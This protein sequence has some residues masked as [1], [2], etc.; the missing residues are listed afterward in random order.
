MDLGTAM[1]HLGGIATTT[2]LRALVTWRV[3]HEGL[4]SGEIIRRGRG[5]YALPGTERDV[6]VAHQF[7]ATLAV[8]SAA[9]VHGWK[10]LEP[11]VRPWLSIPRGTAV[12]PVLRR[13]AFVVRS[14]TSGVTDAMTTALD[15]LRHLP[16]REAACVV[17]SALR[18]GAVA[19]DHLER[20]A[21]KARGPGSARMRST[22]PLLSPLSANPFETCLGIIAGPDFQRQVPI[23]LPGFTVHPDLVDPVNR[24]VLEADSWEFHASTPELFGRDCE[25]YNLLTVAGWIV[26]RFTWK[27]VMHDPQGVRRIIDQA[28]ACRNNDK[29]KPQDRLEVPSQAA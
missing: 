17:D 7:R 6:L 4:A 8:L 20:E 18:S 26:L 19:H 14:G 11:P 23:E 28:I 21:Q 3:I 5:A 29:Y 9:R 22:F 16:E 10:M 24:I 15:C 1:L 27:Q 12:S 13:S 25:R 2:E